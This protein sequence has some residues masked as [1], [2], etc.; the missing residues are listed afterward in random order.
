MPAATP[1]P[2]APRAPR[3][4]TAQ[5]AVEELSRRD[6]VFAALADRYEPPPI[7]RAAPA[8]ERFGTL[9]RAICYQ[10]L[11]GR[12]A[13]TIHGRVVEALDGD[14]TAES[15]MAVDDTTLRACGLS[16]SKA[17][18]IRDLAEQVYAG[19][20]VLER[21]GRLADDDVVAHLVTVRGIGRWTAEMFLLST[22]ARPDVWPVGDFGVRA[23]FATGWA[24]P[25][26]PTP[27]ELMALGERFRP[28]RSTLAWYC[29]R[30]ADDR[31]AVH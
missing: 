6:P 19:A 20:V 1:A 12:A 30:V 17:A 8:R 16:A 14:V 24:L 25:N 13:S 27:L 7:R 26:V 15:V 5:P 18:S 4:R 31:A 9:V 11:A 3:K 21:I 22:L 29:W 10:Q 28:Y 23:G 2:R